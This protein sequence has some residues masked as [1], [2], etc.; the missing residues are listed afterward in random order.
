VEPAEAAPEHAEGRFD[1]L[2]AVNSKIIMD[3]V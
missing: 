2:S 3:D 1:K